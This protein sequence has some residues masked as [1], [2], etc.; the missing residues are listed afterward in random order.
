MKRMRLL[1]TFGLV[2]GIFAASMHLKESS[3][4][5][6]SPR[7][8]KATFAGGCF[9]CMEEVYEDLD[10][11]VSATSGYTGGQA[12]NPKYEEVSAGITGHAEA[13]EVQYDPQKI[14]Y[15]RLLDLF[16]RNVDPTTPNQQFCDHGTQYRSA[17]F[18]HDDVQKQLA[19]ESRKAVERTKSFKETIVTQITPAS[20]FYPAEE[21]HQNFFKKNPIRYKFYKSNCG[22]AQRLAELWGPKGKS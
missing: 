3:A 15:Q 7:L 10:G 13:V 14:S 18:Y 9:W 4:D 17:I 12:P 19:E 1:V 20:A 5:A 8:A 16:W 11:V 6:D 21:Y 22:R 2:V